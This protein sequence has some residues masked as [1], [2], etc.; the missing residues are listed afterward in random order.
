MVIAMAGR[1]WKKEKPL[2]DEERV[3]YQRAEKKITI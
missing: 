1:P 2:T 3:S